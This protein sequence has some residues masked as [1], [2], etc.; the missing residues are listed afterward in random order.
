[1]TG[2][3]DGGEQVVADPVVADPVVADPVVAD[4]VVADPVVADPVVA[5]SILPTDAGVNIERYLTNFEKDDL[6]RARKYAS[7]YTDDKGNIDVAKMIKSGFNLESKFG[8]F[9]GAPDSYTIPTP[10]YLDGDVDLEDPYLQEFMKISKEANM[11]QDG[12][13]K[14]MD[15]H[16][17]SS[18]APP[19]DINEVSK[20][21]G[22]EFDAM[23]N[24]MS[25][26]FQTR[27][28]TEDFQAVQGLITSTETFKALH[29]LYKSCLPT[30]MEDEIAESMNHDDLR[31]QMLAEQFAEDK[32]GNPKMSS[33]KYSDNW[34]TRWAAFSKNSDI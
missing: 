26:F 10:E 30:K 27:L 3:L 7:N 22:P 16:L 21:I 20:E 17:R 25:G 13:E 14:M 12:F 18:I 11:S 19:V 5:E 9:T 24:N 28:S 1:M 4:P 33:K 2:I 15:I 34:H 32:Y 29:S 23:R 31:E 8:S 6:E